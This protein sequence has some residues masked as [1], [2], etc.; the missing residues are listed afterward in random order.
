VMWRLRVLP[1][2][3]SHSNR[4]RRGPKTFRQRRLTE[5]ES[6]PADEAL[7]TRLVHW[8]RY[9]NLPKSLG[10]VKH[11]LC[12]EFCPLSLSTSAGN[13]RAASVA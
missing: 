13:N 8:H 11:F 1:A 3:V 9:K 6:A 7:N 12:G 10:T 5:L 4:K 2:H